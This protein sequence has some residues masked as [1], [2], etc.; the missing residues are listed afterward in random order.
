MPKKKKITGANPQPSPKKKKP[1]VE[2]I[3]E[4]V[5]KGIAT[6]SHVADFVFNVIK[7][8]S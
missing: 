5:Q 3:R 2:E 8:F 7:L 1:E 4:V 6:G